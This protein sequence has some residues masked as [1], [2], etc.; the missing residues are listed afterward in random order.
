MNSTAKL[1]TP[2]ESLALLERASDE[3]RARQSTPTHYTV[4]SYI[5]ARLSQI[6]LKHLASIFI[7]A[8]AGSNLSVTQPNRG[9]AASFVG[10]LY[11][12]LLQANQRLGPGTPE[13]WMQLPKNAP[14]SLR[15]VRGA[16]QTCGCNEDV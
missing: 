14:L 11:Q 8:S 3:R 12:G 1:A 2:G 15:P 9:P 4:G 10:L 5:A 13:Q 6:G 16:L 7:R